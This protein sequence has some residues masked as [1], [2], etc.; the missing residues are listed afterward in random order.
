MNLED[1]K[2]KHQRNMQ[3]MNVSDVKIRKRKYIP[4]KA[5]FEFKPKNDWYKSEAKKFYERNP[6]KDTVWDR[7]LYKDCIQEMQQ[8]P[9]NSIDLVVADPPFG[10]DFSGKE[11]IYNRNERN[12]VE[13]YVE[14]PQEEYDAFTN[15]WISELP[16]IMKKTSSA[17]IFSGWT[18][19]EIVLAAIRKAGLTLINQIIWK[20]QFGVFTHKKFVT[21]HYNLLFA[22]KNPKEYFF[23][24]ID[25]YPEDVWDIAREYAIREQKN[26]TKLPSAIVKKCIDY[27]SKPGALVLDPF[28]GNGTTAMVAKANYRH[29]IGFEVNSKLKKIIEYNIASVQPGQDY[30]SYRARYRAWLKKEEGKLMKKYP[31]AYKMWKGTLT[32]K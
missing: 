2:E 23:N 25:H 12:V 9:T 1:L 6:P 20:Y 15:A 10:I 26:G 17:Y 24:K 22:V 16:R 32:E 28:M 4:G 18:N 21:S 13:G 31:K 5:T 3:V 14:V 11:E 8:L 27:G 19:L 7:I 30:Q 29:F